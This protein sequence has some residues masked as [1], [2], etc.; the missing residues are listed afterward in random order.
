MSLDWSV[1]RM[2]NFNVLTTLVI[3]AFETYEGERKWLPLTEALIWATMH[4]GING[5][6]EDNWKE[7][8]YRLHMWEGTIG[9]SLRLYDTAKPRFITP[10]EVYAH[11][12]LSTNASN[13]TRA[14]F[15][16]KLSKTLEWKSK[17][18]IE[19][20]PEYY[21]RFGFETVSEEDFQQIIRTQGKYTWDEQFAEFTVRNR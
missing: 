8:Y 4:V 5:I 2:K 17:K 16:K 10:L 19:Q 6:T 13:L 15:V 7:F 20:A 12:G 1:E 18:A 21:E 11:I 9:P 3:P 14:Q